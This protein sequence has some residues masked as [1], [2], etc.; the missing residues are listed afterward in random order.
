MDNN[1]DDANQPNFDD[2]RDQMRK[3]IK[4]AFSYIA[5]CFIAAYLYL[6]WSDYTSTCMLPAVEYQFV[7]YLFKSLCSVIQSTWEGVLWLEAPPYI[8]GMFFR[9]LLIYLYFSL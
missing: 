9:A 8:C 1:T 7:R 3:I 6:S 2:N 5:L 4:R